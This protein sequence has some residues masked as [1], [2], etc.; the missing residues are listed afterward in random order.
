VVKN[1]EAPVR[2][3]KDR[4]EVE[5]RQVF[6]AEKLYLMLNKPRGVVTTASD[7]KGR[8]TVYSFLPS[9]FAPG[10]QMESN[11]SARAW[12][13]PVGRLDEASEGLLL[14]TNDSE[15]AAR[16]TAP[17]S[18]LD[19]TYQVQIDKV[20]DQRLLQSLQHGVHSKGEMLKAKRAALLRTGEKNSWIE[21]VLDE[22]RNRQIRRMLE[23]F[24]IA[25]LRLIRVA[26]GPLRLG[27]LAK[28]HYRPLEST[29]KLSLDQ[30]IQ[31][32]DTPP[33]VRSELARG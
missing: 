11:A 19:K 31:Q 8:K 23:G 16:I 15:W 27:N 33:T 21:V 4:V 5:G 12:I 26:I 14:F 10:T 22:G 17:G 18:H 30:A 25:V 24:G 1:P 9:A 13:A 28:G 3:G 20:A 29:E 6:A 7:E 2:L 32:R